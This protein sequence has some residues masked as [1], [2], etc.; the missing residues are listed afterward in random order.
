MEAE[1]AMR[2]LF[3]NA[4]RP[5]LLDPDRLRVRDRLLSPEEVTSVLTPMMTP[6]RL[7]RIDEVIAGRTNQVATV[8]EGVIDTGNISAVMRSAEGMGFHRFHVIAGDAPFKYSVRTSQGAQKWLDLWI[9]DSPQSCTTN[10]K[11]EG[12]HIVAM[13]LDESA[14]PIDQIDFTRK[15]ALVFGNEKEGISKEMLDLSDTHCIVP[16]SGFT[17]SFNISV[18]AAVSLYHA[19]QDRMRRQGYHGD[20]RDDEKAILRAVYCILSVKNAYKLL[21]RAC[22]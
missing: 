22:T 5:S 14:V 9:W 1:K 16:M 18:A 13:H 10:L 4:D 7:A 15:T 19:Y 21:E 20:L 2:L 11:D 8:V 3:S 6:E 17:Q 12:Y